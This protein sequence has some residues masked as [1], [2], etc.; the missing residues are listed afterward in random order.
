[1]ALI[2]GAID[3][4]SIGEGCIIQKSVIGR[5]CKIGAKT[6]IS[7]SIILGNCIIGAEC[8]IQNAIILSRCNIGDKSNVSNLELPHGTEMSGSATQ[9]D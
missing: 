1:V 7:N 2:D 5:N 6:K 9:I 8:I 4:I 3:S